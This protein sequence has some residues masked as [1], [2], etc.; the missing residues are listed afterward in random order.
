MAH[1]LIILHTRLFQKNFFNGYRFTVQKNTE[2]Y[3]SEMEDLQGGS[4]VSQKDDDPFASV[5][6]TLSKFLTGFV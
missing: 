5:P 4:D 1:A 6:G 3:P 2:S